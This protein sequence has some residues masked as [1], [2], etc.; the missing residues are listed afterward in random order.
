MEVNQ[1]LKLPFSI[2][3]KSSAMLDIVQNN[4]L[5]KPIDKKANFERYY[6]VSDPVEKVIALIVIVLFSPILLILFVGMKIFKPDWDLFYKQERFGRNNNTFK[7]IKFTTICKSVA[8]V[9]T[10]QLV[11]FED[12]IPKIGKFLRRT[13]INE[14]PQL[15]NIL[16]G[17]M[18]FVGPR[19]AIAQDKEL[20]E[21]RTELGLD[22]LKPGLAFIDR[23]YD[24]R[25]LTLT[26]RM[27]L[28]KLYLKD[29]S[30]NKQVLLDIW[31]LFESVK[32]VSKQTRLKGII[33][34]VKL[35]LSTKPKY[36][37][38]SENLA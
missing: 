4:Q 36:Y 38:N 10:N 22:E 6:I 17:K 28:E 12:S 33:D 24:D 32:Y 15:Y 20:L 18:K 30:L 37:K 27:R 34:R 3:N 26:Q 29:R 2:M 14:L 16:T 35:G 11:Q 9:P 13:R 5:Q 1:P 25:D 31:I 21:K 7:M 8:D 19:P 23:L